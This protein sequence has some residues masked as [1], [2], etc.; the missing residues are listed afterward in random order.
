M[1]PRTVAIKIVVPLLLLGAALG[2]TK[3]ALFVYDMPPNEAT[4]R[5]DATYIQKITAASP[6]MKDTF[7]VTDV[8]IK[9]KHW[10]IV[11]VKNKKNSDVLRT[12][13]YDPRYSPAHIQVIYPPSL[14]QSFDTLMTE[15]RVSV[16]EEQS[17]DTRE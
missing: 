13:L 4:R 5:S 11:S 14:R 7:T 3:L 9:N 8:S 12:L 1:I 10:A 2:I 6:G 17:D 16:P 15:A